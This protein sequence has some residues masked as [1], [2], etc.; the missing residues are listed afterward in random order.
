[1]LRARLGQ[2]EGKPR[3]KR[4]AEEPARGGAEGDGGTEEPRQPTPVNSVEEKAFV[5]LPVRAVS[6]QT[7][8]AVST[9]GQAG[10]SGR[11]WSG[12]RLLERAMDCPDLLLAF[13]WP[14]GEAP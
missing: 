9:A 5:S 2:G 3:G 13:S 12:L 11:G 4:E 10:G 1:M 8:P 6:Q 14:Q 7:D